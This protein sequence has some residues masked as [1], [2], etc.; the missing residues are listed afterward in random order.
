MIVTMINS[1]GGAAPVADTRSIISRD[2]LN[3]RFHGRGIF[4]E[5]GCLPWKTPISV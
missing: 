5:I 2:Q 4:R 1:P 3:S